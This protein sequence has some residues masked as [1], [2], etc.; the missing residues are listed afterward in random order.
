MICGAGVAHQ[1]ACIA[2]GLLLLCRRIVV[3][4]VSWLVF[5]VSSAQE[6]REIRSRSEDISRSRRGCTVCQIFTRLDM[7]SDQTWLS[8]Y[9][10]GGARKNRI[11]EQYRSVIDGFTSFSGACGMEN[12]RLAKGT[13][14][15]PNFS[16]PGASR[17]R[18]KKGSRRASWNTNIADR[19]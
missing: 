1:F 16:Q 13:M 8:A 17:F 3:R 2:F 9:T 18:P 4:D 11:Y 14:K 12:R 7:I 6:M 10:S 19:C 5:V 15:V